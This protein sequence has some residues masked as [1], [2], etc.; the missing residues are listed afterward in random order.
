MHRLYRFFVLI[1]VA[2]LYFLVPQHLFG[3][4]LLILII[5]INEEFGELHASNFIRYVFVSLNNSD[6]AEGCYMGWVLGIPVK[7]RAYLRALQ[8]GLNE[9]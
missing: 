8:L 9:L 5:A 3:K 4:Y 6:M 2:V 7:T 1:L